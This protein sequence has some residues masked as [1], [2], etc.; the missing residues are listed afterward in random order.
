MFSS[1]LGS[2]C[3][4]SS[5]C[6]ITTKDGHLSV[7]QAVVDARMLLSELFTGNSQRERSS[8]LSTITEYGEDEPKDEN[9]TQKKHSLKLDEM[10]NI[11]STQSTGRPGCI[12]HLTK[13]IDSEI[14]SYLIIYKA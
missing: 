11:C 5:S 3:N 6:F 12:I 1:G 10:F 2:I 7:Y 9:G 13:M 4:S 14:V 8:S